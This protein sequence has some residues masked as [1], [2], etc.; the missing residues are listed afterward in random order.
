MK[1]RRVFEKLTTI[2]LAGTIGI[3]LGATQAGAHGIHKTP[4]SDVYNSKI[5]DDGVFINKDTMSEGAIQSFLEGKVPNC[6]PGYTCLKDYVDPSVNKKASR[7]IWEEAQAVG[8]NPQVILVTLQKEQS[9]VTDDFPYESQYRSAM[10][11]GC[12]ESQSVCDSQYYGFY[13][14]V[15]LGAKLLRVGLDR[16]CGN[17]SSFPGW[18]VNSRW[19][20]NNTTTVDGK[21]TFIGTC[22]TGSL[23]NYTPHRADSGWLTAGDGNHYYGNYNFIYFFTRWFGSTFAG[24]YD[25]NVAWNFEAL[26]GSSSAVSQSESRTGQ[27]PSSVVYNTVLHL[28][29]YESTGGNLKHAYADSNGWHFE[30]LDGNG[31]TGGRIS[32]NLGVMSSVVT[33]NNGIHVFYYDI[34]NGDLRHGWSDSSGGNWTFETLDGS[35]G[36]G[37]YSANLGLYSAATVY[38]DS[39]QLFYY[40]STNGNLR[41]A[42]YTVAAGWKYENLD[43]DP[44]S[45]GRSDFNV[46]THSSV[47]S[48]GTS[49][50]LFYYDVSRGNLRHAW[51]SPSHGWRFENLEGD[52]GSISGYDSAIGEHVTAI[53]YGNSLQLFYYDVNR[54]N[55]RHAWT[56]ATHGWKFENLDGDAGSIGRR[57]GNLGLMA[58]ATVFNGMLYVPYFNA[59]NNSI[60][61][62]HA[63]S[64]GWH[65][66]DLDGEYASIAQNNGNLGYDPVILPYGAGIQMYYYD[67]ELGDLR[68]AWGNLK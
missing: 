49:L 19:R 26:E 27:T 23:Y 51:T 68:H 39:L 50:Q 57:D 32:S 62:A 12:P 47:T 1:V 43:G 14:Q 45:I 30:T 24:D 37:K 38:G 41:H 18:S 56:S 29:Y 34:S 40:D 3:I 54:G 63:D 28:F 33:F 44:G 61:L 66:S 52:R 15:R 2:A 21:S 5:I 31:G 4:I 8:L 46:G 65:F 48:Y 53:Q 17:T 6:Q 67:H 9:L 35:G 36:S 58:S 13:N 16:N 20:V 11:Y 25:T 7:I 42:W 64:T 59:S 60:R 10:G 22:A 55:L